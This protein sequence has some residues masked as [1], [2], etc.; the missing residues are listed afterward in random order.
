MGNL[1]QVDGMKDGI[2]CSCFPQ[3][4]GFHGVALEISM[5]YLRS[6]IKGKVLL[7]LII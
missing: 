2:C 5:S 4:R 3:I 1:I 6:R 7:G